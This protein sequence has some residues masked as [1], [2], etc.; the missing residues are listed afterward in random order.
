MSKDWKRVE[1]DEAPQGHGLASGNVVTFEREDGKWEVRGHQ[2]EPV[3]LGSF[4]EVRR[5]VEGRAANPS[6]DTRK[7]K[8]RLLR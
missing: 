5:V 3:V 7:L 8:A 1:L 4:L 2:A 6:P